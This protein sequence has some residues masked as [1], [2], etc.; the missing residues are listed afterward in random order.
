MS[1]PEIQSFVPLRTYPPL[2]LTAVVSI[3]RAGSAP[4]LGSV[5]ATYVF[6][7]FA[8][9]PTPNFSICSGVPLKI[10][11]GGSQPKAS[12]AGIYAP[13]RHCAASSATTH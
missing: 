7:A 3:E 2:D 4:P 5:I 9:V 1:A 6:S 11:F 12:P 13:I 10:T 8:I